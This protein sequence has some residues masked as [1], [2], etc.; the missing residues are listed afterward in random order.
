MIHFIEKCKFKHALAFLQFRNLLPSAKLTDIM[1]IF[2]D[3]KNY[4]VKILDKTK[5]LQKMQR[6]GESITWAP[7]YKSEFGQSQ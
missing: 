3:R 1:E 7:S 2:V 4:Q 6:K 5:E